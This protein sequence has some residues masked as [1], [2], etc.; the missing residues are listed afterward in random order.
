MG[1][2]SPEQNAQRMEDVVFPNM[3]C[4]LSRNEIDLLIPI[5]KDLNIPFQE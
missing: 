1:K 4:I 5:E 2:M 3:L